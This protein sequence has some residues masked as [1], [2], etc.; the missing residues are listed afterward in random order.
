MGR[1][2]FSAESESALGVSNTRRSEPHHFLLCYG[3]YDGIDEASKHKKPS[4]D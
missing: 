1:V 4:G 2:P 3:A